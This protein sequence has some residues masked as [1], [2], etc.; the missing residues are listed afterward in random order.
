MI[1][2]GELILHENYLTL[3][4]LLLFIATLFKNVING[5]NDH[6]RFNALLD[7]HIVIL[8]HFFTEKY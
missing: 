6:N 3:K 1:L 7:S 2:Y 5:E 8:N 4:T